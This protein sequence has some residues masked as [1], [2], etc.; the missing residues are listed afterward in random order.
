MFG[1]NGREVASVSIIMDRETGRSRGFA[2]VEMTTDEF[3]QQALKELDGADLDGR[4]LRINE[5]RERDA[6]GPGGPP[7]PYTPRPP[8]EGGGAPGGGNFGPPRAPGGGN[9][10]P[11]RAPGG[12]GADDRKRGASGPPDKRSEAKRGGG[13]RKPRGGEDDW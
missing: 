10:G 4:A 3:A 8:G 2:F 11:P 9:F 6:R 13:G 5:A 1:A 7:R 12:G